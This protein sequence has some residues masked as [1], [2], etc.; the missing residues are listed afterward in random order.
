MDKSNFILMQQQE[1]SRAHST[2]GRV[3]EKL[4]RPIGKEQIRREKLPGQ[5]VAGFVD[6]EGSF[7]ISIG[8]GTEYKRGVQVRAEFEIELRADDQEI[9]ERILV[10]IGCGKIYDCS[11]DRYG[12]YPHSKYKITGAQDMIN[13]LFPFFDKYKL[14]AKKAQVYKLFKQVV[15][16]YRKKEH[17]TDAG[18]KK[19]VALRDKMR[20]L[21]RKHNS[22]TET[23]RIRE[24]RSSGGVR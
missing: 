22:L 8:K 1:V 21:G 11:Y 15:L 4:K 12:W 23:A 17:L 14:Q 9:L 5:Y 16:M 24:N 19:V 7:C 3:N 2:D 6:G 18:Y 10:T 20:A 13:Y